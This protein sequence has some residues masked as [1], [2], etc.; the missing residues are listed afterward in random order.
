M[1]H[2]DMLS[3]CRVS[4]FARTSSWRR[5]RT[6]ESCCKTLKN[7]FSSSPRLPCNIT[8][9]RHALRLFVIWSVRFT[10]LITL[11]H[12]LYIVLFV[13]TAISLFSCR[14]CRCSTYAT[15]S[16]CL[17][18]SVG[19][20]NPPSYLNARGIHSPEW[21][22]ELARMTMGHDIHANSLAE[23]CGS[24]LWAAFEVCTL[25]GKI[26]YHKL[27]AHLA[28]PHSRRR[29]SP[30]KLCVWIK[31]SV[32]AKRTNPL[33]PSWPCITECVRKKIKTTSRG[34]LFR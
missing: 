30:S 34:H 33:S 20:A 21:K 15:L 23:E 4:C 1:I 25:L 24:T 8:S 9:F 14:R 12:W 7:I 19:I 28:C 17:V 32:S 10:V 31:G 5:F 27:C 2:G 6:S 22:P 18:C 29:S 3:T 26:A 16:R 11:T 13:A